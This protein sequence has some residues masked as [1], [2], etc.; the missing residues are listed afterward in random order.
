M[1]LESFLVKDVSFKDVASSVYDLAFFASGYEGR[2]VQ[3]ISA[4]D[5][6]AF[7][8]IVVIGFRK[9][10]IEDLRKIHDSIFR[11]YIGNS[12]LIENEDLPR[13]IALTMET[14]IARAKKDGRPARILIDYSSMH[15][16]WYGFMLG[17]ASYLARRYNGLTVDFV[18]STGDYPQGY[19]Q[20][21]E[22]A[23]LESLAPL[24]GMEGLSASRN[25]SIAIF[26]LGFSPIAGLGA[27]ERLQP[28]KVLCFLASPGVAEEYVEIARRCNEPLIRRSSAVVELPL[29]SLSGAYRGISELTWPFAD[30]YH[31][32]ILP[33]GPKPHILASM[34]VA[35]TYKSVGCL[36]GKI[37]HQSAT[38]IQG[39]GTFVVASIIFSNSPDSSGHCP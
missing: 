4:L 32:N 28:D 19:E 2:C 36:Y 29:N 1:N 26:G 5:C 37:G 12:F 13:K 16:E 31:I 7:H 11:K 15:R 33:M 24:V 9:P 8:E 18:Y 22:K 35:Q 23:V 14:A 20:M 27:L 34:L 3:A 21:I 6:H 10:V 38:N 39:N 25:N 30:R 17:F